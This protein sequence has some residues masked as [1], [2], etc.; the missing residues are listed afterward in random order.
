MLIMRFL[1][2]LKIKKE[3]TFRIKK[4]TANLA[5]YEKIIIFAII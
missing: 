4:A 2:L 1:H 3:E 5:N